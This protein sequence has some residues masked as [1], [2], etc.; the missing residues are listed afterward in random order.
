MDIDLRIMKK[1]LTILV[2]SLHNFIILKYIFK[3]FKLHCEIDEKNIKTI[4]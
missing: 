4:K 3:I 2:I 1:I